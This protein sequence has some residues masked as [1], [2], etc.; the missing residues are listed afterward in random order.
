[1]RYGGASH[2]DGIH[3]VVSASEVKQIGKDG[4]PQN[5]V[6]VERIGERVSAKPTPHRDR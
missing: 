5:S 6:A 3:G 4:V 2:H 1:M